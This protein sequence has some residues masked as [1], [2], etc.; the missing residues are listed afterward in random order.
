M[1]SARSLPLPV[2]PTLFSSSSSSSIPSG[3]EAIVHAHTLTAVQDAQNAL[4]FEYT[5]FSTTIEQKLSSVF[6]LLNNK[7]ADIERLR[8]DDIQRLELQRANDLKAFRD[9][10]ATIRSDQNVL[11]TSFAA[12]AVQ[13]TDLQNGINTLLARNTPL[14]QTVDSPPRKMQKDGTDAMDD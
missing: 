13:N 7:F 8:L 4:G 9:E 1:P 2:V 6:T 11:N 5:A 10:H 3:I 14:I 12:L